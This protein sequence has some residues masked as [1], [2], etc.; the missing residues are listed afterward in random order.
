[1]RPAP[2]T[3]SPVVF[4]ALVGALAALAAPAASQDNSCSAKCVCPCFADNTKCTIFCGTGS[5]FCR[6][7]NCGSLVGA[8]CCCKVS[9]QPADCGDPYDCGP[10]PPYP[11]AKLCLPDTA[12]GSSVALVKSTRSPASG[13]F[14]KTSGGKVLTWE[15]CTPNFGGFK[16]D[17]DMWS[18]SQLVESKEGGGPIYQVLFASDSEYAAR[19]QECADRRL[20]F[21]GDHEAGTVFSFRPAQGKEGAHGRL[22]VWRVA[23][24]QAQVGK[25]SGNLALQLKMSRSGEVL[26]KKVLFTTNAGLAEIGLAAITDWF[27]VEAPGTDPGPFD[28]VLHLK[29]EEGTLA[30]A[31]QTHYC[32]FPDRE[33][34][35]S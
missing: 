20:V 13:S 28:D 15:V 5:P 23:Q 33:R 16:P 26:E 29:F 10:W 24:A 4:V 3:F 14:A 25:L 9:F 34:P 17:E 7:S 18:Y 35:T 12:A 22:F 11:C 19:F 27:T 1:M 32:P 31:Y 30:M 6:D 8:K 21:A 2:R